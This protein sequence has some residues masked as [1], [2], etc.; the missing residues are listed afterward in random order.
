MARSTTEKFHELKLMQRGN[1]SGYLDFRA[2]NT[3]SKFQKIR[4][5]LNERR[6]TVGDTPI[7]NRVISHWADNDLLPDGIRDDGGWRKFNVVELIWLYAAEQM[8][9]FGLSLE[10]I[11]I[12]RRAVMDWD[13]RLQRYPTFEFFIA[14][15]L[16]SPADPYII[17]FSDGGDDNV[18]L[19][20]AEQIEQQKII[21]GSRHMLLISLKATL[22]E[23]FGEKAPQD[24]AP[25]L[26]LSDEEKELLRELQ[27]TGS[28]EVSTKVKNGQIIELVS[29]KV[30]ASQNPK[31]NEIL[32]Q[33][34]NNRV[35]GDIIIRA[36]EGVP[37]SAEIKEHK[38]F[39]R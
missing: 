8:R 15:A 20:R 39:R 34:K 36:T 25:L 29:K 17:V 27:S 26:R 5:T 3:G 30:A 18:M 1:T 16:S 19:A 23:K 31:L 12:V 37:Q 22:K 32:R 24:A 9:A 11:A 35:S 7:S 13:K 33:V 4:D 28:G 2:Y 38:R 14:E 10:R 21:F 6:Y